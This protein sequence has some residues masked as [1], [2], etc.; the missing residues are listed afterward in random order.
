MKTIDDW[1]GDQNRAD[2]LAHYLLRAVNKAN[3][4]FGLLAD[5]D[6]VL[7]AVSGGKD[8]MTMLDLLHRYR[9]MASQRYRLVAAHVVSD[10]HCGQ[11]V[12]REWLARWCQERS[13]P[14]YT[15]AVEV[16]DDI[17]EGESSPCFRCAWQRRKALFDL[18]AQQ[19]CAKVAFGHHADDIAETTLLNL[20]YNGRI[21]P[22]EPKIRLFDGALTV[23]RPLALV[24]ERDIVPF[25][26]ASGFPIAGEPC[27]EGLTSRRATVK[28]VLRELER[29]S[30]GVKRSIFRAVEMHKR[31]LD[32]VGAEAPCA[33]PTHEDLSHQEEKRKDHG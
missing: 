25:A 23:I 4:C 27:P 17:A 19:G 13:L 11:A 12:P 8:S 22:M 21:A 5:G 3:F 9:R 20:F 24:E 26:R 14:L 28:R 7:V 18:A 16:A 29:E 32:Q 2:R 1:Q 31:A 30:R 15:A 33:T 10:W 6:R